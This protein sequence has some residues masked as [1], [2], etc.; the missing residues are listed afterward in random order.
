MS[1]SPE[2][3]LASIAAS[4]FGCFTYEQARDAGFSPATIRRRVRDGAWIRCPGRVLRV[5][6]VPATFRQ[7][8]MAATLALPD[9]VA[10]HE[11]AA[12]LLGFPMIE[13]NRVVVTMP[14]DSRSSL[15]GVEV[16][17]SSALGPEWI[18]AQH[19]IPTTVPVRT[20]LDL[21]ASMNRHR[22]ERVLDSALDAGVFDITE[23][24]VAFNALAVRGRRGIAKVRPLLEARGDGYLAA[25]SELERRFVAFIRRNGLPE[26]VA[27]LPMFLDD[28]PVGVVDFAYP[29]A[30]LIVELD[31]RRGH[32]QLLDRENDLRR[33]GKITAHGWR[34]VR[35]TWRMLHDRPD[36]VVTNLRRLLSPPDFRNNRAAS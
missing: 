6:A 9:S 12:A 14:T 22:L 29:E 31:G 34:V 4:Q 17:R 10:S 15:P 5:A 11:T 1:P 36:E 28:R 8:V 3:L 32:T 19:G 13:R 7:R 35:I 2:Q 18:M 30:R 26:P 24:V 23:L 25:T 20:M 27:Q 33:D 16:H 21:G